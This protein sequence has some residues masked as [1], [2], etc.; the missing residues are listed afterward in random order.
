MDPATNGRPGSARNYWP[1]TP[2]NAEEARQGETSG[3]MRW[4]LGLSLAL[5]TAGFAALYVYTLVFTAHQ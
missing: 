2:K 3:N 1:F 4:V 5:V